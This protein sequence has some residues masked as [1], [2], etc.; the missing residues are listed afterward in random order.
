[1]AAGD[2]IVETFQSSARNSRPQSST[3]D[4]LALRDDLRERYRSVRRQSLALCVTLVPED[5]VIQTM[6]E[7]SPTKWHLAHTSWFFETF[8]LQPHLPGYRCL[9]PQ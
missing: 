3:A 2:T 4:V 5:C 8:L 7:A 1:M 9:D 6:P